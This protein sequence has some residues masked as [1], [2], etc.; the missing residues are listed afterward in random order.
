M[1][2]NAQVMAA[3]SGEI[4]ACGAGI[5]QP[6]VGPEPRETIKQPNDSLIRTCAPH[7]R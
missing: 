6:M 2:G 3:N 4:P 7:I 5:F 1:Q